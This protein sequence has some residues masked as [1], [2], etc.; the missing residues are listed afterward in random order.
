MTSIQANALEVLVGDT[1]I[2][3]AAP[4]GYC[5]LD[6]QHPL[7]SQV[8]VAAQQVL[9]GRNEEL[10]VFA[11]CNR[12]KAWREGTAPDLGDAVDYQVPLQLKDRKVSA[13]AVIPSVCAE[14]RKNGAVA[15]KDAADLNK[16]FEAMTALAGNVKVNSQ[17]LYGVLHED[18]TGCYW[19]GIQKLKIN[20]SKVKNLFIIQGI[21]VVKG[22]ALV[23]CDARSLGSASAIQ[24]QLGA[25]R[26]TIAATLAQN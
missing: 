15:F 10:A 25:V 24:A 4:E 11:E 8:F 26:S 17:E 7:D 18:K 12:L 1:H 20:N 19:G 9:Q 5:P 23:F 13:D 3:V 2:K 22:K 21:T 14:M 6:K 16:G